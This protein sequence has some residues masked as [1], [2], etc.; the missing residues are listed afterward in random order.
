MSQDGRSASHEKKLVI[1]G[2]LFHE[3]IEVKST[4]NGGKKETVL[5]HTR[6]IGDRVYKTQQR[7]I[8]GEVRETTCQMGQ[9]GP[10]EF[11]DFKDEWF[12][13]WQPSIIEDSLVEDIEDFMNEWDE[14]DE[15]W[16]PSIDN[17][18][19]IIKKL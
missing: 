14:K 9:M 3:H 12:E 8:D 1:D 6:A 2:I 7:V 4:I 11:E 13:K 16:Q 15:Y 10:E 19:D 18:T 5:S 17:S